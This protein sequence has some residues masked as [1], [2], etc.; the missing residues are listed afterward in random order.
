MSDIFK[1][2]EDNYQ[3]TKRLSFSLDD[4]LEDNCDD[5]ELT[6]LT[7]DDGIKPP[8]S[9]PVVFEVPFLQSSCFFYEPDCDS[10][11]SVEYEIQGVPKSKLL[12]FSENAFYKMPT[13]TR[14]DA[15]KIW[16]DA[17]IFQLD[18]LHNIESSL[19]SWA[20]KSAELEILDGKIVKIKWKSGSGYVCESSWSAFVKWIL[21]ASTSG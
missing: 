16:N 13:N 15:Y 8:P 20:D 19:L 10:S 4:Y 14:S 3:I 21:C 17:G 11:N 5:E 12:I 9:T 18:T 7:S 6:F 2:L 1:E